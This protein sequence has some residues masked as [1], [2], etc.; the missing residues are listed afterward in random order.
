M[1]SMTLLMMIATR[2]PRQR[3]IGFS[4]ERY[5]RSYEKFA[6]RIPPVIAQVIYNDGYQ[7]TGLPASRAAA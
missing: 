7:S 6:T 3:R 5:S 1:V 4:D 2:V